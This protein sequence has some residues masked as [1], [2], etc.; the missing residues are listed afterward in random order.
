MIIQ[1]LP[2][3]ELT[4]KTVVAM[5]RLG[6]E[7][8]RAIKGNQKLIPEDPKTVEQ[9]VRCKAPKDLNKDRITMARDDRIEEGTEVIV[10]G[11]LRDA[12]QGVGVIAALVGLELTLILQK[13]GR[14]GQED[15]KGTS[16]SVLYRV[17]GIGAGFTRVREVSAALVQDRLESIEA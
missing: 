1:R 10:T 16:G 5:D 9:M 4:R 12:K 7:V 6:R 11:N 2:V 14:L 13:R 3:G 15:A 17:T 8:G